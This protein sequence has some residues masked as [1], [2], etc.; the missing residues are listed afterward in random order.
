MTRTIKIFLLIF[1][2]AFLGLSKSSSRIGPLSDLFFYLNLREKEVI[3]SSYGGKVCKRILELKFMNVLSCK[4]F[5]FFFLTQQREYVLSFFQ[6]LW[7]QIYSILLRWII[8]MATKHIK[9][10]IDSKSFAELFL[11]VTVF[12]LVIIS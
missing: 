2:L 6:I 7:M 10:M 11:E 5:L 3:I 4:Y 8:I 12:L 1:F 9:H